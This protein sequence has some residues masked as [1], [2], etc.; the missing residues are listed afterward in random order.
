[1]KFIKLIFNLFILFSI[2]N[3]GGST[4]GPAKPID[5]PPPEKQWSIKEIAIMNSPRSHH[6]ATVLSNGDILIIGGSSTGI[7]PRSTEILPS[8]EIF[9][10][11]SKLFVKSGNLKIPRFNH[12]AILLPSGKVAVLGGNKG[13]Y[14][15][16][17]IKEVEV[18]DPVSGEFSINGSLLNE[19]AGNTAFLRPDGKIQIV[20]GF[21]GNSAPTPKD[22]FTEI[23]DTTIGISKY[24]F[25]LSEI[26]TGST[27]VPISQ[28]QFIILGGA[29]GSGG[30]HQL[31]LVEKYTVDGSTPNPQAFGRMPN[32]F[33]DN[34]A[35]NLAEGKIIVGGGYNQQTISATDVISVI[36]YKNIPSE[37]Q[38]NKLLKGRRD[39]QIIQLPNGNVAFVGG[40]TF[41]GHIE[42]TFLA[43]IEEFDYKN[44]IIKKFP[45][46]LIKRRAN[47]I[48]V[49]I[50]L[51][52]FL[53]I[54]GYST[55]F[56]ESYP[57]IAS[58]ELLFLQ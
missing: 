2:I 26:R 7:G 21:N 24:D 6:T 57:S 33:Q 13:I 22:Y 14:G 29:N 12:A 16:S 11:N 41:T 1:M 31:D 27:L 32:A 37:I 58:C 35:I 56:G 50:N 20:G 18:W 34:C 44:K 40:Q 43:D 42:T 25:P 48:I 51:N 54:G 15:E 30:W 9:N 10:V 5:N 28:N 38:S 8:S 23:Y 45:V 55:E 3:C 17:Y 36:D 46:E 53:I 49:P 19:H 47:H 52:G 4:D 39:H